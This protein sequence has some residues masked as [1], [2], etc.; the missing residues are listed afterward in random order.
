MTVVLRR[1]K[2]SEFPAFTQESDTEYFHE[3]AKA[4]QISLEEATTRAQRQI[5]TIRS[6]GFH[7]PGH[8]YFWVDSEKE[9][10]GRVWIFIKDGQSYL[11]EIYLYPQARGQGFGKQTMDALEDFAKKEGARSIML[12]VFAFNSTAQALYQKQGYRTASMHMRK[13]LED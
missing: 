10:I 9:K 5:A 13:S 3:R 7:T 2:E 8:H 11:Y 4:D 1:V 6:L 12:N